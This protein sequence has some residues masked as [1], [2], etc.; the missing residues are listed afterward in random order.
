MKYLFILLFFSACSHY[1]NFIDEKAM[2]SQTFKAP[3]KILFSHNINGELEPCGC[4]KFPLGGLEQI[5][6]LIHQVQKTDSFIYLDSGDTFFPSPIIADHVK[7]SLLTTAF[8]L[9][10]GLARMPLKYHLPGDQD[11]ALG[12][13]TY[14]KLLNKAQSTLLIS[15]LLKSEIPHQ[16]WVQLNIQK[17]RLFILGVVDPTLYQP[18]HEKDFSDP[19]TSIEQVLKELKPQLKD[20]DHVI[21]LSHSGMD[22]D[23]IYAQKFPRINWIIGSHSLGF[24]QE[25]REVEKTRLV[26]VLSKNHYLG[27]IS[28]NAEN[29]DG[30]F[31]LLE[32]REDTASLISP[33]PMTALIYHHRDQLKRVQSFE[34][35]AMLITH[36]DHRKKS[37][38]QCISCHQTQADFWSS[39]A[40]SSSFLTLINKKAEFNS[41]CIGCHSLGFKDPQGFQTTY[42]IVKSGQDDLA[43]NKLDQYLQELKTLSSKS[44]KIRDLSSKER[45]SLFKKH[46]TVSKKY[47]ITNN[48]SHVQC[49][50]CHQV[51]DHHPPEA[52]TPVDTSTC[53]QCH[54]K[55][56]SPEWYEQNHI[57]QKVLDDK[58]KMISCPRNP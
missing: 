10:D 23:E 29:P 55:D 22:Q 28:F 4:S 31:K 40:H 8:A 58:V 18:E 54:T 42:E 35:Q 21:L 39:T 15:N 44:L 6:G 47:K 1:V 46:Q 52:Q 9:A 30:I 41:Q 38:N 5:K 7:K 50:N 17:N 20:S 26:Q 36:Q 34:Q 14:L 49:L 32:A 12:W 11:L 13:Q 16:K 56:Q 45:I 53:L 19:L 2:S 57:N 33:N 25:P 48:L 3:F 37:F 51:S 27:E 43:K 24:T